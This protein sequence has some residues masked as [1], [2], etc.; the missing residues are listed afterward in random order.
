MKKLFD[1]KRK[2]KGF[3][4]VELIV[5]VAIMAV[6]MAVLVPTLV[7]NVEKSRKQ[8]DK[9]A[10]GEL[11][12]AIVTAMNEDKCLY[13]TASTSGATATNGTLTIAALFGDGTTSSG[14]NSS[15]STTGT[16]TTTTNANTAASNTAIIEE[17]TTTIGSQT[18]S[19]SSKYVG[20]TVVLKNFD[21][22]S[23][24]VV[25]VVTDSDAPDFYI[26]QSGEH[27]GS[28]GTTAAASGN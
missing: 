28:Y 15:T 11:R 4:L 20:C 26:D 17:V 6:L 23:G 7:R 2:N 21:P 10:L 22:A 9:S 13:A 27:E 12:N 14:A 25:M 8:K 24:T 16:T 1:K 5:V 18:I 3:S 19:L